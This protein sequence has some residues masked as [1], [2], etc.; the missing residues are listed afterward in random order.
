MRTVTSVMRQISALTL[1]GASLMFASGCQEETAPRGYAPADPAIE[2]TTPSATLTTEDIHTRLAS[3]DRMIA[4]FQLREQVKEANM[5]NEELEQAFREREKNLLNLVKAAKGSRLDDPVKVVGFSWE[6]VA[7]KG[8][9]IPIY[10]MNILI[11]NERWRVPKDKILGCWIQCF[12]MPEYKK[13]YEDNRVK[14]TESMI[15]GVGILR[16]EIDL[17]RFRKNFNIQEYEFVE[18]GDYLLLSAKE[19]LPAIPYNIHIGVLDYDPETRESSVLHKVEMG[20]FV[21][22]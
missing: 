14:V 8:S 20:I 13:E 16:D 12:F 5:M 6:A 19:Q 3:T 9:M 10:E 22:I 15:G 11:R 21:D 4:W 1:I 18:P 17:G 7:G 2:T